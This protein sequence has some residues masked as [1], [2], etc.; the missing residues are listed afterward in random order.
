MKFE[1][2]ESGGRIRLKIEKAGVDSEGERGNAG[3]VLRMK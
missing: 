1:E 3:L 2:E